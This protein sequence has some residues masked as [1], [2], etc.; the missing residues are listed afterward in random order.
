[1]LLDAA[2]PQHPH[3]FGCCVCVMCS[4]VCGV[5]VT[6]THSP[7][8]PHQHARYYTLPHT[9]GS[10][11]EYP[12]MYLHEELL[13]QKF[14]CGRKTTLARLQPQRGDAIVFRAQ[15]IPERDTKISN[16]R[17]NMESDNIQM[18]ASTSSRSRSS[19]SSSHRTLP[20]R[21]V[22]ADTRDSLSCTPRR[23]ATKWLLTERTCRASD[24]APMHWTE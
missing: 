9:H 12:A 11:N 22:M 18:T 5:Y 4:C 19:S 8:K 1:M 15:Q 24:D 6:L 23:I 14:D 7:I 21:G 20:T 10:T 13:L 2:G 17:A 16:R 3:V